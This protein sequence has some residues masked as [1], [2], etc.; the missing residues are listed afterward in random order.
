MMAGRNF[1]E[2]E[3]IRTIDLSYFK[4]M[5]TTFLEFILWIVPAEAVMVWFQQSYR[6]PVSWRIT[7]VL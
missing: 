7:H 3:K 4:H 6:T 5:F 2:L 1:Q